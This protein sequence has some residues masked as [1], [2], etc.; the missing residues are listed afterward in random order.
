VQLHWR[1]SNPTKLARNLAGVGLV[2]PEPKSATSLVVTVAVASSAV[3]IFDISNRIVTS[4]FD[5]K[6]AQLFE[7]FKFSKIVNDFLLI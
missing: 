5:S 1:P 4:V 7:V 2:L 3:R 6:Q